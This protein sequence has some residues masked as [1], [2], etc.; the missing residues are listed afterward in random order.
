MKGGSGSGLTDVQGEGTRLLV[1]EA[2][3]I[4]SSALWVQ[5]WVLPAGLWWR[6]L[7]VCIPYSSLG[8]AATFQIEVA[9]LR[10]TLIYWSAVQGAALATLMF[11][12]RVTAAVELGVVSEVAQSRVTFA[13]PNVWLPGETRIEATDLVGIDPGTI[14][15]STLIIEGRTVE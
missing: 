7:G 6:V 1:V 11:A 4:P 9:A 14:G 2:P 13:L 5:S 3:A 15:T 8:G 10:G 12:G